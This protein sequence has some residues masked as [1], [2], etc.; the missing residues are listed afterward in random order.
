MPR[1]RL[2]QHFLRTEWAEQIARTIRVSRY[3]MERPH[4]QDSCW[5][6]IGAG[7]GEMTE[8]LAATGV[9]VCAVELDPPL[10]ARLEGLQAR[11]S[12]LTVMPGD[13]LKTD[14]AAIAA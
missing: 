14:L 11:Y 3:G 12:N 4:Q 7:H 1:Q 2:G 13:V 10:V 9:P 5:I 6:E 8:H